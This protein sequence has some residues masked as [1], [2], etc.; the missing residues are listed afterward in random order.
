[1]RVKQEENSTMGSLKK[2]G[3]LFSFEGVD[4]SGKTTQSRLLVEALERNDKKAIYL[5]EP[6]DGPF[7]Q[8]IKDLSTR[9]KKLPAE[10]EIK[11][12]IE[13]RKWDVENNILPALQKDITVIMDRYYCSNAAY[14]GIHIMEWFSIIRKNEAFAPRPDLILIL[15][16]EPK[17]GLERIAEHRGG[18]F[19]P[20]FERLDELN[21]IKKIFDRM[22]GGHIYHL[23]ASMSIESLHEKIVHLAESISKSK[24]K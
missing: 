18:V 22:K 3:L 2:R 5:K 13:D 7:G 10:E 6:T 16:L 17:L 12:F 19:N 21:K 20:Y 8:K 1:M 24:F 15:D 9:H 14:Q 4:G 11:L 23:D